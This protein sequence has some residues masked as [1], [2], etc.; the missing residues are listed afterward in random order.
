[1][2]KNTMIVTDDKGNKIE[3]EIV[4]N[5]KI[6]EYNKEYIIYTLND[7]GVSETVN[8]YISQVDLSSNPPKF[9]PIPEEEIK[10]VLS[11]YDFIR[12]HV[13]GTR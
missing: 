3:V 13:G 5:F 12:D 8:M 7:D 6:K 9:I 10:M 4:A 2:M 1:M 11:Y